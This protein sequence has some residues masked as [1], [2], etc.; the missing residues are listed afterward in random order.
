VFAKCH[1][2][3][4]INED[5][6]VILIDN[7]RGIEFSGGGLWTRS[8]KRCGVCVFSFSVR[9]LLRGFS[10]SF[11]HQRLYSPLLGPDPFSSTTSFFTQPVVLLG[12]VI[13]PPQGRYLHT[14]QHK[15]RHPCLVWDSNPRS[16]R[17]SKGR[18]FMPQTPRPLWWA[19]VSY[20]STFNLYYYYYYYYYLGS[21]VAM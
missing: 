16:Q 14:G 13:S 2:A 11:I 17:S 18:Q 9:T 1:Y 19:S 21:L 6:M 3:D 12:R 15:H 4:E 8:H 10:Y 20:I 7:C 5:E